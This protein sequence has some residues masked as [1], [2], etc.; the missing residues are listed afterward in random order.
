MVSRRERV[1]NELS[2]L[3]MIAVGHE[4]L[5]TVSVLVWIRGHMD[6]EILRSKVDPIILGIYDDYEKLS[7]LQEV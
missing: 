5:A 2:R 3:Y 7:L 1:A 4:D 6:N